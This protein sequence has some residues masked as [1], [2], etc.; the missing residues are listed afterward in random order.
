MCAWV[1]C[2]SEFVCV[3]AV[4][5]C[6][7]GFDVSHFW[8]VPCVVSHC[9]VMW[10]LDSMARYVCRPRLRQ[11][12][13]TFTTTW[14]ARRTREAR[15]VSR[16]P[17]STR[18]STRTR[19]ARRV[20]GVRGGLG[21]FVCLTLCVCVSHFRLCL[22]ARVSVM[23]ACIL[24][25]YSDVVHGRRINEPASHGCVR[26]SK[27]TRDATPV[28][29]ARVTHAL[30]RRAGDAGR[31]RRPG[32][33]DARRVLRLYQLLLHLLP[34]VRARGLR[35]LMCSCVPTGDF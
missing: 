5:H 29:E 25:V 33:G 31:V 6:D 26:G 35:D 15:C 4:L 8:T 17:A 12:T 32:T 3:C 9:D 23:C 27:H 7:S 34:E 21:D 1:P 24:V 13:R 18:R 22:V 2:V 14:T 11:Q 10:V 20:R 19:A 30:R 28:F 16:T